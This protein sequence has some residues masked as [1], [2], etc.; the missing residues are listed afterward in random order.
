MC[1]CN[2]PPP[3]LCH[4]LNIS[5][6]VF[7]DSID[8]A[9]PSL[10]RNRISNAKVKQLKLQY[11][12]SLDTGRTY[13]DISTELVVHT[14]NWESRHNFLTP[15]EVN[16]RG[17]HISFALFPESINNEYTEYFIGIQREYFK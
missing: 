15:E 6:L 8:P 13:L 12:Y 17:L 9:H 7:E 4:P 3:L 1:D 16:N 2:P 5:F 10:P 11:L 14:S